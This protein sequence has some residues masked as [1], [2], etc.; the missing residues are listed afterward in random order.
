M[1]DRVPPH[2][3]EAEKSV[4]GALLINKDAI[5]TV[6]EFLRASH[7]YRE[8]HGD[9]Y[10][11][12]LGLYERREPIDLVTVTEELKRNK[13]YKQIGGSSYLTELVNAVPT[14]AHIEQYGK[15]VHDHFIRRRLI[16]VSAKIT[17][18]YG[19]YWIV[20]VSAFC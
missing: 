17:R 10:D 8:I 18:N 6:A 9:I 20:L 13:R 2:S 19:L 4:L 16:D 5:V 14:A 7:F 3:E 12:M 11:A 15:I 1:A